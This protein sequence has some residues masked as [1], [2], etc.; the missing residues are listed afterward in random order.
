MIDETPYDADPLI[1]MIASALCADMGLDDDCD[2]DGACIV[3]RRFLAGPL[4]ER[5]EAQ[6]ALAR[7][8]AECSQL[9]N[10]QIYDIAAAAGAA[11]GVRE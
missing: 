8:A 1:E 2:F 11:M 3:L 5:I 7:I 9:T 6:R 10:Q 4:T